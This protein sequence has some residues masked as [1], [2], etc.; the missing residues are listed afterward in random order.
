M[1]ITYFEHKVEAWKGRWS[2]SCAPDVLDLSTY[3][4]AYE[5]IN[6]VTSFAMIYYVA[7]DIKYWHR[8]S[9]SRNIISP[10]LRFGI[11][12][13][14]MISYLA[15]STYNFTAILLD[16]YTIIAMI[17]FYVT[18][19]TKKVPQNTIFFIL[20][21]QLG[22]IVSTIDCV[23]YM[24]EDIDRLPRKDQYTAYKSIQYALLA[25]GIWFAD[26]WWHSLWFLYGHAIFH[27]VFTY[28]VVRLINTIYDQHPI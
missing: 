12:V 4:D 22:Y 16:E 14:L 25:L 5:P 19:R 21:D 9:K 17:V 3:T 2:E 27:I 18:F 24:I 1:N 13:N 23:S 10:I 11:M 6:A 20:S 8:A 7:C 26:Q 28:N 15:H